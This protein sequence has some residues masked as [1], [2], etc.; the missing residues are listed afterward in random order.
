M[1]LQQAYTSYK[2]N[3]RKNTECALVCRAITFDRKGILVLVMQIAP[4][5]CHVCTPEFTYAVKA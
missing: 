3:M 5:N 1:N 4:G 2:K